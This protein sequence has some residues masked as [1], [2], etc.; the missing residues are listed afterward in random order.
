MRE[1][2]E[3]IQNLVL[4]MQAELDEIND[5]CNRALAAEALK[6]SHNTENMPALLLIKQAIVLIEDHKQYSSAIAV[7]KQA[8][9]PAHIS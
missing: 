7:L 8:I 4:H 3:C 2:I 1:Q 9:E 6:P 5:R